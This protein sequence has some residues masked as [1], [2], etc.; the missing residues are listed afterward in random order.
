MILIASSYLGWWLFDA[1]ALGDYWGP[2]GTETRSWLDHLVTGAPTAHATPAE[3]RLVL[4]T[5]IGIER[6]VISGKPVRLPLET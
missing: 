1:I 4:E 3:A 2:L 5:T 6:S